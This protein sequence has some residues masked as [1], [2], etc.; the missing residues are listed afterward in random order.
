MKTNHN[1]KKSKQMG[2][3]KAKEKAQEIHIDTETHTFTC[4][5]KYPTKS[6]ERVYSRSPVRGMEVGAKQSTSKQTSN[7]RNKKVLPKCL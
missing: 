7:Q 4:T 1:K 3:T 5:E 6:Q 2:K